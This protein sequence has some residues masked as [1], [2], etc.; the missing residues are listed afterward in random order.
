MVY[1]LRDIA[2]RKFEIS[3]QLHLALKN[4]SEF[5]NS[6]KTLSEKFL[7]R[8]VQGCS[9]CLEDA[10]WELIQ[11]YKKNNGM[12]KTVKYKIR[13]G[14]LIYDV[15]NKDASKVMTQANITDELAEYHLLTN[16]LARKYFE[17]L[18]I[19]IDTQ[20][21]KKYPGGW[22]D[23]KDESVIEPVTESTIESVTEPIVEPAIELSTEEEKPKG[24]SQALRKKINSA[25]ISLKAGSDPEFLIETYIDLGSTE[26]EAK[27]IIVE[28]QK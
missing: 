25:R 6:I 3:K 4:D 1:S 13:A 23:K 17:N 19:D 28:A 18:P 21:A 14:A 2:E 16:K 10:Y 12:E 27:F 26:E 24:I 20:L 11:M 5:K 9:N 7:G 8:Q 22:E 15:I